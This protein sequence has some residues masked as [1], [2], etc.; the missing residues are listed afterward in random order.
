MNTVTQLH[1]YCIEI[2]STEVTVI[3]FEMPMEYI[4]F[5]VFIFN[6]ILTISQA[7]YELS[8]ATKYTLHNDCNLMYYT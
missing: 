7:R 4:F 3:D 6:K 8:I 2:V 5:S 1:A